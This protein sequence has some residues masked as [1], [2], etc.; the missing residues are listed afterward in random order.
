MPLPALLLPAL[1]AG[2]GGLL[3]WLGGRQSANSYN[4]LLGGQ[5]DNAMKI[6]RDMISQ[7]LPGIQTGQDVLGNQFL[8]NIGVFAGLGPDANRDLIGRLQ[9]LGREIPG[10]YSRDT[11][12]YIPPELRSILGDFRYGMDRNLDTINFQGQTEG[13]MGQKDF[14]DR[15][16]RGATPEMAQLGETGRGLMDWGGYTPELGA[17]R[18]VNMEIFANRGSNYNLSEMGKIGMGMMASGGATPETR[19]MADLYSKLISAGG[20]DS[21]TSKLW[22]V[23]E[24]LLSGGLSGEGQDLMSE[25]VKGVKAKG[26]SPEAKDLYGEIMKIVKAG[27]RG[28]ALLPEGQMLSFARDAAATASAQRAESVRRGAFQQTGDAVSAGTSQ[29]VLAEFA[30]EAART[31]AEAVRDAS[32]QHQNLRLQQLLGTTSAG[33][34]LNRTAAQALA[35]YAGL[36]SSLE[37]IRSSNMQT[38][39]S[40]ALGAESIAAQKLAAAMSAM[41]GVWQT[42]L[43]RILGGGELVGGAEQGILNRLMFAAESQLGVESSTLARMLGGGDLLNLFINN[44]LNAGQGM[45]QTLGL[46]FGRESDAYR[47]LLGFGLGSADTLLKNWG[48]N[49][50]T[51]NSYVSAMLENLG[52]EGSALGS[53]QGSILANMLGLGDLSS[54]YTGAASLP[55]GSFWQPAQNNWLQQ[56]GGYMFGGGLQGLGTAIGSPRTNTGR[57]AGGTQNFGWPIGPMPPADFRDMGPRTR[58]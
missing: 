49:L 32:L 57:T 18:D 21:G 25:A 42:E 47:N 56:L 8:N 19:K 34:D 38:G 5:Y 26:W 23:A 51:S 2:G 44:Q 33:A 24:K 53:A 10:R 11:L 3:S 16:M 55:F 28:G 37:G 43:A 20:R 52:L 41:Q 50:D 30:D 31:E 46:E 9:S 6:F 27:G 29:Q 45:N 58:R 35:A 17:L 7:G 15:I 48:F 12:G 13:T 40:T 54:F 14:W 22:G 39:A 4:D 36:G 1:M